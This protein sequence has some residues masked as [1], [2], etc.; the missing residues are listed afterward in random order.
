MMTDPP[1]RTNA[2]ASSAARPRGAVKSQYW[3]T[4]PAGSAGGLADLVPADRRL[5]VL[6]DDRGRVAHERGEVR[7][8]RAQALVAADVQ[9]RAGGESGDLAGRRPHEPL[10]SSRRRCAAC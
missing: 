1:P 10:A 5:A 8:G 2:S 6:G 4:V 7:V 9:V 3:P